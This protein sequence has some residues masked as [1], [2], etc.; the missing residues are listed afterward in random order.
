MR[1]ERTS[2]ELLAIALRGPGV[3]FRFPSVRFA[4]NPTIL[5]PVPNR[6][7]G[8]GQSTPSATRPCAAILARL[9]VAAVFSW[10]SGLR[11]NEQRLA[12]L[13]RSRDFIR[14]I[15]QRT[16]EVRRDVSSNGGTLSF[17]ALVRP[18]IATRTSLSAIKLG[19]A[20]NRGDTS[21]R[22]R[23]TL[24][25]GATFKRIYRATAHFVFPVSICG[26]RS[27]CSNRGKFPSHLA[28]LSAAVTFSSVG[29][30]FVFAL[31]P[32]G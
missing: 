26:P 24:A 4:S 32:N 22:R 23:L 8:S 9:V 11:G 21:S 2:T 25:S 27:I 30:I 1:L 19:F 28:R 18:P 17:Y 29:S 31:R 7:G 3:V 20:P 12:P 16:S 13:V 10:G 14:Q 15:L 6:A 5:L